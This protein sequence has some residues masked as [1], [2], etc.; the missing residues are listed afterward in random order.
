MRLE[1]K[2]AIVTGGSSG[3]GRGIALRLAEA[4]ASVAIGDVREAPKKGERYDTD[5]EKPTHK[6]IRDTGGQA[7]FLETDV[8]EPDDSKALVEHTID[9]FGK[10]DILVNNAGIHIPGDAEE[11]SIEEFRTVVQINLFGQFYCAKYAIP[12]L[13]KTEGSIINIGSIHAIDGGAGPPYA[14]AKAGVVNLTKDLATAFGPDNINANAVCPGYVKTP[15]QDYLTE[16]DIE[17]S[18]QQTTLPRFG[19]PRDIGN[20]VAFLASDEAEWI[21]G[22][23]LFVDGGWTAHR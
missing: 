10:L 20:A 11:I 6:R 4:G 7:T 18:R 15:M 1:D 17:A 21:T 19:E 14:S 23:S 16:A 2:T 8:S 9:E 22:T 5:V 12:Y 3:I 13:R